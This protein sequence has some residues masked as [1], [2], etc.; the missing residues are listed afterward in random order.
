MSHGVNQLRRPAGKHGHGYT[1]LINYPIAIG[2]LI[3]ICIINSFC[4]NTIPHAQ[5]GRSQISFYL[6]LVLEIQFFQMCYEI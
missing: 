6:F 4:F 3:S 5:T 1:Y 2:L